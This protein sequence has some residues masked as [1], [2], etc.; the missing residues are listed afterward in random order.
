MADLSENQNFKDFV[1]AQDAAV[2]SA[3]SG[4]S[5]DAARLDFSVQYT[6]QNGDVLVKITA[7]SQVTSR[8]SQTVGTFTL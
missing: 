6:K 2:K 5:N 4:G 7:V 3:L 1:D 8:G